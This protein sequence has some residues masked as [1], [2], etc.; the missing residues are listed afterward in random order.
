MNNPY[1]LAEEAA[2]LSIYS[3]KSDDELVTI[4]NNHVN[5]EEHLD[6]LDANMVR[7]LIKFYNTFVNVRIIKDNK[8]EE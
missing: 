4:L 1:N 3:G 5:Q 2:Y 8:W 6:Q 7:E